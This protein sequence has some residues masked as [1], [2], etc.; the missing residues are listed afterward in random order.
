MASR[1]R[2]GEDDAEGDDVTY[3]IGFIATIF[4]ANWAIATFGLV[5]V[6]F[7]LHAPAGV[8]FAGLAFTL[9]DMTQERLGAGWTA[10]AIVMGALLSAI[11]S[12]TFALASGVAFLVSEGG[13]FLVYSPMRERHWLSAVI[14]SNLVGLVMDS[15]IFLWLAFGSLSYLAGQIVGK[16]WMT[17]IPVAAFWALR[18]ANVLPRHAR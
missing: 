9:R 16:A 14:V 8:Y 18:R 11:V 13:D 12:P 1:D 4:A 5:S 15:V 7:G 3:L 10:G 6:G 17:L 2:E